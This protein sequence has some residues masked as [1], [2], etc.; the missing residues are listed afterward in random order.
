MQIKVT[1]KY[2]SKP[3]RM[4]II[5]LKKGNTCWWGCGQTGTLVDFWWEC[6][7]VNFLWKTIWWQFLWKLNIELPYD[8]AIPCLGIYP[9]ESKTGAQTDTCSSTFNLSNFAITKRW[10]QPKHPSM[11]KQINKMQYIHTMDYYLTIKSDWILILVTTW[12][13]FECT[14]LSKKARHKKILTNGT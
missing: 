7:M 13:N 1:M 9:K 4:M 6:K 12:M 2:R 5:F 3:M 10:N 8:P 14:M 11:Y